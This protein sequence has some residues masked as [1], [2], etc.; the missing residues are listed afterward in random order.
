MKKLVTSL[1]MREDSDPFRHFYITNS[2]AD[3]PKD[4]NEYDDKI[5][6]VL[7]GKNWTPFDWLNG[8]GEDDDNP[9]GKPLSS[10]IL[11][12]PSSMRIFIVDGKLCVEGAVPSELLSLYDT[13][14]K[15]LLSSVATPEGTASF[16]IKELPKGVYIVTSSH[17]NT[18]V[19]I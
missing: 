15:A 7:T 5:L 2:L 18:K 1:P 6:K 12:S 8:K 16:V 9:E 14:G 17:R 11:A 13:S 3:N 10:E 4:A 19:T